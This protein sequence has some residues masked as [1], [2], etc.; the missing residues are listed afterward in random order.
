[1]LYEGNI[2]L[3]L[4]TAYL[5]LC[6]AT[7][8]TFLNSLHFFLLLFFFFLGGKLLQCLG[9]WYQLRE[10]FSDWRQSSAFSCAR[11]L[12]VVILCRAPKVHFHTISHIIIWD[13]IISSYNPF[14]KEKGNFNQPSKRCWEKAV[15]LRKIASAPGWVTTAL[16]LDGEILFTL[17]QSHVPQSTSPIQ[18]MKGFPAHVE[19]SPLWGL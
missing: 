4:V 15:P 12:I 3:A 8:C 17:N 7:C 18:S 10:L 19:C 2:F 9:W 1:M 13:I 5:L 16:P 6:K 14:K 11:P